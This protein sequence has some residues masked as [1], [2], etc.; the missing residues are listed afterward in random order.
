MHSYLTSVLIYLEFANLIGILGF[1]P[2]TKDLNVTAALGIDE[3][4]TDRVCRYS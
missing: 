1:K 3:Y 4:C 2:P